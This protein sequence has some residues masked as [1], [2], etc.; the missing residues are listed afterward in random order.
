MIQAGD[1]GSGERVRNLIEAAAIMCT[2]TH[3]TE[4]KEPSRRRPYTAFEGLAKMGMSSGID[5]LVAKVF[6]QLLS[7]IAAGSVYDPKS[8]SHSQ[9]T[10]SADSLEKIR[11]MEDGYMDLGGMSADWVVA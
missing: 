5:V 10:H 6:E 9:R 3:C 1:P 8:R 4:V 2:D 11:A 7:G